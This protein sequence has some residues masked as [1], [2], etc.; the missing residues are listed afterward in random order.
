MRRRAIVKW[1]ILFLF[2]CLMPFV[3]VACT[4]QQSATID[5]ASTGKPLIV[6]V[7]PWAGFLGQ[8]V[9]LSK[10]LF[11]DQ[12]VQVQE[13]YFQSTGD[14]NTA[15]AAGRVDLAWI[16]GP[17]LITLA[18]EGVNLKAIMLSDYS[19]GSDGIV[20]RNINKPEDIKGKTVAREDVLYENVFLHRYLEKAGLT[21]KDVKIVSMP[22]ADAATAFAAGK[23]DVAVTYEPWLSRA[24]KEGN[25][26]IIFTTKDTNIIPNILAARAEVIQERKP[27]V[28]AYMRTI[29]KAVDF[30]EANPE[31]AAQII[32][33]KLGITPEEI[34]P[35]LTGIRV[36]D[37]EGNKTIPFNPDHSLYL[38]DSFEASAQVAHELG[39]TSELVDVEPLYDDSLIKSL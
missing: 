17:D 24:V 29:G 22:A 37:I 7:N 2:G 39:K 14:T 33:K 35:Q 25:G 4:S 34:P 20:G 3:Q 9:A 1:L 36:L 5:S 15:L 21:E 28:I 38:L 23:V 10:E 6:G 27:E 30:A 12:G 18:A 11:S 13:E 32:A 16:G 31:E 26:Q 19:N 8:Y